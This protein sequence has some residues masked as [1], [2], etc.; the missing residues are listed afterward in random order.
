MKSCLYCIKFLAIQGQNFISWE[1]YRELSLEI[2][3]S[4]LGKNMTVLHFASY[5][6]VNL[7]RS[8]FAFRSENFRRRNK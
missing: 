6:N 4:K 8:L 1:Y 2:N 3:F 7:T 5:E